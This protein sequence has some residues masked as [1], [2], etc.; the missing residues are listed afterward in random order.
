MFQTVLAAVL[1]TLTIG[2]TVPALLC[3]LR[4]LPTFG[5]RMSPSRTSTGLLKLGECL[6]ELLI[7]P[8]IFEIWKWRAEVK[9]L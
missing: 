4:W 1:L 8:V 9:P 3:I 7:Y 2:R 6:L 5:E